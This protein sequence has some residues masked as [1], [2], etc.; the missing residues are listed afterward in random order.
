MSDEFT[1]DARITEWEKAKGPLCSGC[2]QETLQVINGA[3]RSCYRRNEK[4]VM[5]KIELNARVRE[6][7]SIFAKRRRGATGQ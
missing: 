5:A 6:L 2:G 7:N 3:C 4:K 1:L